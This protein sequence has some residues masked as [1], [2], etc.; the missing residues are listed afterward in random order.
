MTYDLHRLE[1]GVLLYKI[2]HFRKLV[3][4]FLEY[5]ISRTKNSLVE[6]KNNWLGFNNFKINDSLLMHNFHNQGCIYFYKRVRMKN[7]VKNR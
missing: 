5:S 6:Q 1:I 2:R 7:V 3:S 4:N